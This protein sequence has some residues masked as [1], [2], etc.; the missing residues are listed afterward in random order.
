MLAFIVFLLLMVPSVLYRGL[1]ISY[2]WEWFI[3]PLGI[4]S[5]SVMHGAGISLIV[6]A[7]TYQI[8]QSGLEESLA[9]LGPVARRVVTFFLSLILNTL[10]FAIGYAISFFV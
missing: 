4:Q 2:L 3:T 7:L 8:V 1:V 9:K 10:W 5:I 6:A